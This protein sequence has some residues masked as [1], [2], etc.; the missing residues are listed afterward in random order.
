[1]TQDASP[2]PLS[3][4]P[5]VDRE[6][7]GPGATDVR[8]PGVTPPP[9]SGNLGDTGRSQV[10]L[11][12]QAAAAPPP[13]Q[14]LQELLA[15]PSMSLEIAMLRLRVR[16][17]QISVIHLQSGDQAVASLQQVTQKQIDRIRTQRDE[18]I[19]KLK[20]AKPSF[21]GVLGKVFSKAVSGVIGLCISGR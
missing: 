6:I 10:S 21:W 2:L 1:M 14:L 16:Q 12:A 3:S 15:T 17:D 4:S 7:T 9:S 8:R 13:S 20:A 5:R 11:P 18:L 19:R